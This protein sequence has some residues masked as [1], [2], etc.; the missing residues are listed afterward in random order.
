MAKGKD[1]KTKTKMKNEQKIY[2]LITL[3]EVK[4]REQRYANHI[5]ELRV[6]LNFIKGNQLLV[7]PQLLL[8]AFD[9]F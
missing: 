6:C 2:E 9:L 5:M 8:S 1:S 4:Q 3:S 7:I